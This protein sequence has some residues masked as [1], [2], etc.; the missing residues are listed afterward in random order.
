MESIA[1]VRRTWS[2]RWVESTYAVACIPGWR[3]QLHLGLAMATRRSSRLSLQSNGLKVTHS[4]SA[5][6]GLLQQRTDVLILQ[7]LEV[8]VPLAD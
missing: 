3:A 6:V 7:L 4:L 2:T 1:I 8:S 5:A